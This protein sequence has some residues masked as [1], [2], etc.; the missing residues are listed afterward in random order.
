[1]G[2]RR[3]ATQ[4]EHEEETAWYD[5]M[6]VSWHANYTTDSLAKPFCCCH[7]ASQ[8]HQRAGQMSFHTLTHTVQIQS[9]LIS[10]WKSS[11]FVLHTAT[12]PVLPTKGPFKM[13]IQEETLHI[14]HPTPINYCAPINYVRVKLT[15]SRQITG[16][17]KWCWIIF[18]RVKKTFIM[19]KCFELSHGLP[20]LQMSLEQSKFIH[21]FRLLW[22]NQIADSTPYATEF[23]VRMQSYIWSLSCVYVF[24]CECKIICFSTSLFHRKK[25][26]VQDS[27]WSLKHFT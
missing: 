1:M 20:C 14:N 5:E 25:T 13:C 26:E 18:R 7:F 6:F 21:Y 17:Y 8:L 27:A 16:F 2:T 11:A 9:R 12:F 24:T 4:R 19:L 22:T 15:A 10:R 23:T 3:R